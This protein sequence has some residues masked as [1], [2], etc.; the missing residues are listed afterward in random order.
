MI[1]HH[2]ESMQFIALKPALPILQ[3]PYHEFGDFPAAQ[4][5]RTVRAAVQEPIH[6]HECLSRQSQILGRGYAMRWKTA[7]QAESDEQRLIDRVPVGKPPFIMLHSRSGVCS[8][9]NF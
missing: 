8:A 5:Q 3:G 6:R 1:G 7:V 2:N 9:K 4:M